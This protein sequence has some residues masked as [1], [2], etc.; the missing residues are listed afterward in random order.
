MKPLLYVSLIVAA[1]SPVSVNAAGLP[2]WQF[3]MSK[4]QVNSLKE[5]GPYKSFSN[6]DLETYNGR[7]HGPQN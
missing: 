1:L 5:F 4:S 3:G 7:F 2:P 6:G